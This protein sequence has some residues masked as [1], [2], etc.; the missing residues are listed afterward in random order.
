MADDRRFGLRHPTL[1]AN[2]IPLSANRISQPVDPAQSREAYRNSVSA[3]DVVVC[4][5]H[6]PTT[7][8]LAGRSFD[9]IFGAIGG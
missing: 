2:R 3:G 8:K 7:S 4:R 1:S 6:E 5:D 9:S